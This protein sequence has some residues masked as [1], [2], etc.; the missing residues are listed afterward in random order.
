MVS[1]TDEPDNAAAELFCDNNESKPASAQA[2]F[3]N[4]FVRAVH[5]LAKSLNFGWKRITTLEVRSEVTLCCG[6]LQPYHELP[7]TLWKNLGYK[8]A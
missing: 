4:C 7:A 3:I 2:A 1:T 8:L 5:E 6:F